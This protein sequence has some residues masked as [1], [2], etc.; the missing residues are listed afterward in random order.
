LDVFINSMAEAIGIGASLF[1]I[2]G[3]GVT[4]LQNGEVVCAL[5]L[6]FE[7]SGFCK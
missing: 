2:A 4:A 3:A 6:F 5:N 7:R 1:G